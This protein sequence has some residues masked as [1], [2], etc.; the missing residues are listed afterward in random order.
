VL[1]QHDYL[2]EEVRQ[3]AGRASRFFHIKHRESILAESP[4][5]EVLKRMLADIDKL[6]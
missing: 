2:R 1:A 5:D 3:A 4:D 6:P